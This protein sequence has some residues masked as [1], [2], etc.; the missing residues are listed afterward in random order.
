MSGKTDVKLKDPDLKA[1]LVVKDLK[2][3]TSMAFL[4]ENDIL[5]LEKNGVVKRIIENNVLEQPVLNITSIVN[6]TRERGL[7]GIAISGH[8]PVVKDQLQNVN[9]KVYLYFTENIPNDIHNSCTMNCT[10]PRIVNSLFVYDMKDSNLVNPKLLLRIPFGTADIG[11]EHIGGKVALGPDGRIYVSGGDG[12]P[13]RDFN[14]CKNSVNKGILNS[15]TFNTNGSSAIG[16]GGILVI[17]KDGHNDRGDNI[18]GDNFPLNVYYAYGIRN[19]FGL[20]FD[21]HTG[22]L[23]DTENGPYFGDEI[24][25]VDAG[26]N[27][28]WA[29]AQGIW[30]ISDYR[31]LVKDLPFGYHYPKGNIP[32]DPNNLFSYDGKGKYSAPEFTWNKSTGPTALQFFDSNRLG[33]KYE[34]DMF[35]GTYGKGR[36]YHFQLNEDRNKL[37]TGRLESNVAS[38]DTQLADF[39][40]AKGLG[41]I[42]DLQVSPD[43]YL[44]VLTYEGNLWKISKSR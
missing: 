26:F 14:D 4:D 8:L 2:S 41:P 6:N 42:T 1:A 35:V 27:S 33:E 31:Q 18:L 21:P 19:S 37:A 43:G 3:P 11:L 22:N 7:L 9:S 25:L 40:F 32:S 15:E 13:C 12:Y 5:V 28:G 10:G 38:N 39:I 34:D 16:T 36:I 20:D 29:K 23:W 24:N 17:S 30:S 44:Y